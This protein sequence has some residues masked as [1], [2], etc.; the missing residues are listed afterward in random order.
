MADPSGRCFRCIEDS[1]ALSISLSHADA[2]SPLQSSPAAK[3]LSRFF[4]HPFD[5]PV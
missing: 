2:I 3:V 5:R 1:G 4:L